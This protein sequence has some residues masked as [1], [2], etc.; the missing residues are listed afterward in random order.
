MS[1]KSLKSLNSPNFPNSLFQIEPPRGE[2]DIKPSCGALF[3]LGFRP[4]FLLAAALAAAAV[5]LWI[6]NYAGVVTLAPALPPLLWHGHEMIFGFAGAVIAGFL[7]TAARNW[8]GLPTPTGVPLALLVGLWAAG[9]VALL[10]LPPALAAPIDVAFFPVVALVLL[11]VLVRAG[12]R[13]NYFLPLLLLALAGANALSYAGALGALAVSP[14]LGLHLAVALIVVLQTVIAGRI[15]PSFTANAL[16]TVPWRHLWI[17]RVAVGGTALALVLWA[18]DAS[19]AI[20]A[21]VALPA[22]LAQ[23][24]RVWGWRPFAT[25]RTPLLWILHLSHAWIVVAL[26]LLAA[27]GAGLS[28]SA[29]VLHLLTV[30]STGGLILAMIT[31]TA[32]GHTGRTLRAGALESA[33]YLLLV[34]AVVLRVLPLLGWVVEGTLACL[35]GAACCWTASFALYLAKYLPILVRPRVDGKPG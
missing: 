22:A 21:V 24:A 34:G 9:R 20:T 27:S 6:A 12:N 4:F 13:R 32:L 26:F 17:D 14:L 10:T 33:C 11:R 31:R 8:T 1:P 2:P 5:P 16:R 35:W 25:W 29:A 28:G 19:S 18:L 3:A 30:G 7:L 23:T 15:V